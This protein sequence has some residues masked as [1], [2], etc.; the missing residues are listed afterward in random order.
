M[1]PLVSRA[2]T[3]SN[4]CFGFP[5]SAANQQ[6]S[7]KPLDQQ[8]ADA[9]AGSWNHL[10]IGSVY[11][12]SQFED[13]FSPVTRRDVEGMRVLELGCGNGS[14]MVHMDNWKPALIKGVDLGSSVLTASRNM[15]ATKSSNWEVIQGDLTTFEST[16]FDF[17]YSIGV[18]HHLK[19][20]KCGL[21]AVVRNTRPGGRF[22]CWVYGR[23]GNAIVIAFV[24]PIRRI[25]CRLPWWVN[26]HFI[27]TPLA[28]PF[29]LYGK[30]IGL[31]PSNALFR[32]LPL[33]DYCKWIAVREFL[34]FRHVAFDQLVTPQTAYIRK[35][36]IETWMKSYPQ[37]E[38]ESIY[39]V[40]RNGNS[41]KFGA[42]LTQTPNKCDALSEI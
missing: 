41:W 38:A 21:D 31:L 28:V 39:I 22:H 1:R 25:A 35:S 24:E 23:E 15:E 27:A 36:T 13:W 37:V 32:R 6:S 26:K 34:F 19:D 3:I 18:L 4:Y 5:M 8:T 12:R 40:M 10:P 11:T 9:F 42:R 16:G 20:P 33:F 14:L 30:L 29:F 2:S 17:V 7:S